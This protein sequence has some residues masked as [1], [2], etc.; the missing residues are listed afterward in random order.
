VNDFADSLT[1]RDAEILMD[2][3]SDVLGDPGKLEEALAEIGAFVGRNDRF[4][5]KGT[6]VV[7][8]WD[9]YRVRDVRDAETGEVRADA[10]A[11]ALLYALLFGDEKTSRRCRYVL[12]ERIERQLQPEIE[13]T[14]KARATR[15]EQEP[16]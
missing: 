12:A 11:G 14:F 1:D 2:C 6:M 3:A 15:F 8:H 13:A 16:V 4:E 7:R 10:P 5:K 9:A